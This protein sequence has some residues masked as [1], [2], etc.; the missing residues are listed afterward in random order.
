VQENYSGPDWSE[1]QEDAIDAVFTWLKRRDH[2]WFYLAG[3]AGTGKTTLA[4]GI[5][6]QFTGS[7][8]FG[9]FTGKA[10]A[11]MRERGCPGAATIDSLIYRVQVEPYCA[12]SPPCPSPHC[13]EHC[14]Y[15]R[16]RVVGRERNP[17]SPVVGAKL[18]IIDECSMVGHR[19]GTDLL[20]FGTPVLVLGDV[21]QLPPI[22]DAGFFT[23]HDPDFQLTEVHRQAAGSPVIKLATKARKGLPLWPGQYGDS[24]VV[25]RLSIED[26]LTCDQVICGTHK[27]RN[28]INARMREHL[29]YEGPVPEQGEKVICL[30]NNRSLGL[31][32]G[33][34]WTVA[35]SWG[36]DADGFVK[37]RVANDAGVEVEVVAPEEGFTS[38]DGS[39]SGLGGQ[40]FAFGYAITCHKAQGSQWPSVAIIDESHVFRQH[41]RKWLYTAITRAIDRVIV[42]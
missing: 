10:A 21:A 40:P 9:A 31:H 3:Y 29:G 25:R 5:A 4:A 27:T 11:V 26:M 17:H 37:L 33:T 24:A 35:K 7:T 19:M 23:K 15:L 36:A 2:P 32:N 30:K 34:L 18:C 42:S 22:G 20:S 16:D 8:V 28:S 39:G 6:R 12:D 13:T 14:R 41:R 1:Q 38:H